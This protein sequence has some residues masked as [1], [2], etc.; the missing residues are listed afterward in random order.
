VKVIDFD[1]A[2]FDNEDEI[3][4]RGS[5]NLRAPE[6]I[7]GTCTDGFAADVYSAGI[8]LFSLMTGKLPYKESQTVMGFDM[9]RMFWE[10]DPRYWS[11][12]ETIANQ[13]FGFSSDF[14]TLVKMMT[15]Y[16][17]VERATLNEI[18]NSK[19]FKGEVYSHE[20]YKSIMGSIICKNT[21][22]GK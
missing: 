10:E 1:N 18:K 22:L 4:S 17:A 7:N 12:F 15:K 14:K 11:V 8:V 3:L 21:I 6:I 19:W 2:Q 20:E 16:D 13:D 9:Q 5:K